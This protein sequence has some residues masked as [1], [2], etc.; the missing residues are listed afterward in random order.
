MKRTLEEKLAMKRPTPF[1]RNHGK[2]NPFAGKNVAQRVRLALGYKFSS[3]RIKSP[4]IPL[5]FGW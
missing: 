4:P 1:R 5:P 2:G 3:A